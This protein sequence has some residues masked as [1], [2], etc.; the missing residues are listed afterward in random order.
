MN[1]DTLIASVLAIAGI[2]HMVDSTFAQT[3][4]LPDSSWEF[5][6]LVV[7]LLVNLIPTILGYLKAADAAHNAGAALRVGH[8]N[9]DAIAVV[10]KSVNGKVD[11]LLKASRSIDRAQGKAE[12]VD[13]ERARQDTLQGDAEDRAKAV[14]AAAE[15]Q[16]GKLLA[17]ARAEARKLLDEAVATKASLPEYTNTGET[18]THHHAL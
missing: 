10:T 15:E 16:S 5:Y 12:G 18:A 6:G 11:Q 8:D 1:I 13:Q 2:L 3:M 9:R 7:I 4:P 14:L 17:N